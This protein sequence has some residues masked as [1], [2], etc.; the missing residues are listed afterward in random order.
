[1]LKIGIIGCGS[2]AQVRH[3][4]EYNA[5]P[6][7]ELATFYNRSAEKAR[8]MAERYGGLCCNGIDEL[9]AMGPDAVSF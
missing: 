6:N 9:L 7:C 1:M 8:L 4:P 2:I 3:I 5:N